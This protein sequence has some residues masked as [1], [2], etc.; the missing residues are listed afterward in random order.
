MDIIS[1]FLLVSI[2]HISHM[3]NQVNLAEQYITDYSNIIAEINNKIV[4]LQQCVAQNANSAM[5]TR[6]LVNDNIES[7]RQLIIQ[8]TDDAIASSPLGNPCGRLY[9]KW[10][11]KNE[12]IKTYNTY[13]TR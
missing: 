11:G 6:Q 13:L 3:S 12:N 1:I 9:D 2:V 7:V 10:Y 4:S 8:H 5:E